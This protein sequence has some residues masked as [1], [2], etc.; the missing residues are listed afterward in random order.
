MVLHDI[1]SLRFRGA[2]QETIEGGRF[3]PLQNGSL[4]IVGVE[5]EDG[6]KYVCV[7]LNTEGKSAVSAMLDVKGTLASSI[8]T[9]SAHSVMGP[10][11]MALDCVGP[12]P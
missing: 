10:K 11:V 1:F 3:S 6:G 4:Q 9:G 12:L 5:K 2:T 7:A 8:A